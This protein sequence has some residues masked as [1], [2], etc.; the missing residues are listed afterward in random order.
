MGAGN[1][2]GPA[3]RELTRRMRQQQGDGE[4]PNAMGGFRNSPLRQEERRPAAGVQDAR[5]RMGGGRGSFQFGAGNETSPMSSEPAF[6]D[7][8][9]LDRPGKGVPEPDAFR[10]AAGANRRKQARRSEARQARFMAMKNDESMP[11]A[12]AG[13]PGMQPD[14]SIGSDIG[15][16]FG[17]M[18]GGPK[19]QF[20]E[21]VQARQAVP[22]Q[23]LQAGQQ[24]AQIREEM[25]ARRGAEGKRRMPTMDDEYLSL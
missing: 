20:E 13:S 22:G 24:A 21:E 25:V 23:A 15:F 16:D 11:G 1:M 14:A 2:G 4:D 7:E 9:D 6:G 17:A 18:M 5:D 3:G 12:G 10:A 19:Q 8:A